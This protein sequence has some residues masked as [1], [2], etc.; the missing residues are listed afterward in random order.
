MDKNDFNYGLG[1]DAIEPVISP[2]YLSTGDN[3]YPPDNASERVI[4]IAING[5]T[6]AY[7]ITPLAHHEVVNDLVG[8]SHVAVT[9]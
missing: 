8:G 4:G 6:R 2:D 7:P 5:D 9:Y 1:P 3:G